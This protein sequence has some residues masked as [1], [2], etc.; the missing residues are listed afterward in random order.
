M[1]CKRDGR[2]TAD[3]YAIVIC[4]PKKALYKSVQQLRAVRL[5]HH[6]LLYTCNQINRHIYCSF[7]VRNKYRV[8]GDWSLEIVVLLKLIDQ[9]LVNWCPVGNVYG[10]RKLSCDFNTLVL[11]SLLYCLSR[12]FRVLDCF[13]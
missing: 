10:N 13:I 4:V 7:S 2:V 11:V 5:I 8:I 6:I 3:Y 9:L 12:N 1:F